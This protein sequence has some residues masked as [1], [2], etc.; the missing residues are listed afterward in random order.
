MSYEIKRY[1]GEVFG[2]KSREVLQTPGEGKADD[3][4]NF[5]R[6]PDGGIG[7]RKGYQ[8]VSS[9]LGGYG[10][11]KYE[12]TDV[13]DGFVQ[14]L[15]GFKDSAYKMT[16]GTLDITY[17]GSNP[18]VAI[19]IEVD[20]GNM[21]LKIKEN[22]SEVLDRNLGKGYDETSSDT[23]TATATAISALTGLSASVTGDGAMP[24]A[25][26]HIVKDF[27]IP[28]GTTKSINYFY[29]TE[30]NKAIDNPID[31][32]N[33]LK[34]TDDLRNVDVE[35]HS[36]LF[37]ICDGG[38]LKVYDGQ[39]IYKAGMPI[40]K[41]VTHTKIGQSG[42]SG[43]IDYYVSYEHIDSR[44]KR[45][46]GGFSDPITVSMSLNGVEL[47]VP[48]LKLTDGYNATGAIVNGD[49][50]VS[51]SGGSVTLTVHSNK[52][53][54]IVGDTALFVNRELSPFELVFYKVTA[55]T[56]TTITLDCDDD[57]KV[58]DGDAIS[59][60]IKINLYRSLEAET[61]KTFL[62]SVVNNCFESP[63]IIGDGDKILYFNGAQT[64]DTEEGTYRFTADDGS[65]NKHGLGLGDLIV[66]NDNTTN[67]S[68][69]VVVSESDDT[70]FSFTYG[71]PEETLTV[72]DNDP[73]A[74][75]KSGSFE[76]EPLSI[77]GPPPKS[78]FCISYKQ[79]LILAK[80]QF[81][82]FSDEINNGKTTSSQSFPSNNVLNF[83]DKITGLSRTRNS[84]I[85]FG[86]T[87]IYGIGARAID[88]VPNIYVISDNIG[89]TSHAAITK[90]GDIIHFLS[91]DG[92]YSIV[93]G[94]LQRNESGM[95]IPLSLDIEPFFREANKETTALLKK[96]RAVGVTDTKRK[97]ALFFI[98][99][100]SVGNTDFSTGGSVVLVYDYE[101]NIWMKW[102][103]MNMAGGAEFFDG[104]LYW[105]ERAL[106]SSQRVNLNKKS[107][108]KS[109]LDMYD[110]TDSIKSRY[111]SKWDILNDNLSQSSKVSH[112]RIYSI[113]K[114]PDDLEYKP[115]ITLKLYKNFVP[116]LIH[117][118]SDF[119]M[120]PTTTLW[121]DFFWGSGKVLGNWGTI[122]KTKRLSGDRLT[123]FKFVLINEEAG[124]D[125]NIS[126]LEM[127]W[128][129]IYD[130]Q[131][132]G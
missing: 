119:S 98:P 96:K 95:P 18:H 23:L 101:N 39:R 113:P 82:Y 125:I 47:R 56:S 28:T 16:T 128:S 55:V 131:L 60:N 106:S 15:I 100:E 72:A 74:V 58:S 120:T 54:L 68:I 115:T 85:I 19:N 4:L 87:S 61:T 84:L 97:Q 44:G 110:H 27:I 59:N 5:I 25:F 83:P 88:Q 50:T 30:L 11:G 45:T 7:K 112:F 14:E 108:T 89:C 75:S 124:Q 64:V 32:L 114:Y 62:K 24:S 91:E 67:N 123:S 17:S 77:Q 121:Q 43:S 126:G 51:S 6:R 111:E 29:W 102:N 31:N 22:D 37:Y 69:R 122:S 41:S 71:G 26:L 81:V 130:K 38:D 73:I 12:Y 99:S 93:N 116:E 8:A 132:K 104:E 53:T 52:H 48:S 2:W 35:N 90:V 118:E 92:I 65:G 107:D 42:L 127:E 3:C 94:E 78:D 46:E 21:H 66:F 109:S 86:E 13:D 70:T 57:I 1:F 20:S 33:S 40:P 129:P 103:N 105:S 10:L 34:G 63:T 36:N 117:T 76:I 49:Q 79:N 80:D 9:L